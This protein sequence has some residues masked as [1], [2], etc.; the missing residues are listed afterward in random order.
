MRGVCEKD[1][2]RKLFGN[3]RSV[4]SEATD[5][6]AFERVTNAFTDVLRY[7]FGIILFHEVILHSVQH[8]FQVLF[9]ENFD[10]VRCAKM[11]P[12]ADL[13]PLSRRVLSFAKATEL[14]A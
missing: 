8:W 12:N 10:L 9:N 6:L 1:V 5:L 7:V 13:G 3:G 11:L 2:A 14:S 4:T